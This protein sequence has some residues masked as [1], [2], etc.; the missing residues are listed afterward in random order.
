MQL[1]GFDRPGGVEWRAFAVS[2]TDLEEFMR[3]DYTAVCLDRSGDSPALRRDRFV[4]PGTFGTSTR[5]LRT[6]ALDRKVISL[7]FAIRALTS[8]PA[9]VLSLADRGRIAEGM[10]ADVVIFDPATVRDRATYFEPFQYSEG[11]ELVLTNGVP[12]VVAGKPTE[13]KPGR[14]LERQRGPRRP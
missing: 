5:L 10:K 1:N 13:A 7:P 6:F 9:Q 3:K 8:L 14:V 4:H 11:I 2:L 12:V